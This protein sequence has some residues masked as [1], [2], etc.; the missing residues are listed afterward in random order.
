MTNLTPQQRRALRAQAHHLHPV[1]SIG[2]H[3]L[4][5]PVLREIDVALTAHALVKI[6]VHSDDRA[7]REAMLAQIAQALHAAP[8]QH[9]SKLLIVWREPDEEE[10]EEAP[11][12]ARK[13]AP[14]RPAARAEASSAAPRAKA[15]P[16]EARRRRPAGT[17]APAPAGVRRTRLGAKEEVAG[18]RVERGAKGGVSGPR[19]GH[20]AKRG[21]KGGGKT[22]V[23]R[24]ATGSVPA[25]RIDP[26]SG[27]AQPVGSRRAPAVGGAKVRAGGS[28]PSTA[29]RSRPAAESTPTQGN[30]SRRRR[31]TP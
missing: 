28:G 10:V 4:T 27:R 6:R 25:R 15:S 31:R 21:D 17:T 23:E 30:A 18:T 16:G 24:T 8:V 1:V 5:P 3:G 9:L 2:Q 11:A 26:V 12:P 22:S 19:T 7:A 20:G 13:A 29:G 14:V